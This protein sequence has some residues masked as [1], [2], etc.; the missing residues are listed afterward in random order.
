MSLGGLFHTLYPVKHYGRVLIFYQGAIFLRPTTPLLQLDHTMECRHGFL[1]SPLQPMDRDS[2]I[3]L[4]F[5]GIIVVLSYVTEY[6]CMLY[7]VI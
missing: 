1:H 7:T 4:V 2:L 3:T 6:H 5:H